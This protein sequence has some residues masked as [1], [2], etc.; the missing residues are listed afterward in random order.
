MNEN[1]DVLSDK[2]LGKII[3]PSVHSQNAFTAIAVGGFLQCNLRFVCVFFVEL[4]LRGLRGSGPRVVQ[5][6]L[7]ATKDFLSLRQC[8]PDSTMSE[9]FAN[10]FLLG[11]LYTC[12]RRTR[13]L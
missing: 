1:V 9:H 11:Y 6:G 13:S 8:Q 4:P 7:S 2:S 5:E 10:G 12:L 3:L